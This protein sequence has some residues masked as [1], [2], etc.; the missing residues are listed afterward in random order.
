VRVSG[1]ACEEADSF[2]DH[3]KRFL[4]LCH[5]QRYYSPTVIDLNNLL[6][7]LLGVAR[8]QVA[9]AK[10]FSWDG[11]V[12]AKIQISGVLRTI[13]FFDAPRVLD[14]YEQQGWRLASGTKS[15]FIPEGT[16]QFC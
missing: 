4:R 16:R 3:A 7:V 1:L 14:E 6:H 15:P 10:E 11:F 13:P 8:T 9:L 5:E 2:S 12:F